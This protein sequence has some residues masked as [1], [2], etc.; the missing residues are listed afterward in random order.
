MCTSRFPAQTMNE[1]DSQSY[2]DRIRNI[3]DSKVLKEVEANMNVYS[4]SHKCIF[5]YY[6]LLVE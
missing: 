2:Q 3:N 1:E 6:F 5:P 4:G